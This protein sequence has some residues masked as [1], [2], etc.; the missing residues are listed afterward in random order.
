MQLSPPL[1]LL[2]LFLED[3]ERILPGYAGLIQGI[4]V[5]E[6][7]NLS[8]YNWPFT[9]GHGA[10]SNVLGWGPQSPSRS[11]QMSWLVSCWQSVPTRELTNAQDNKVYKARHFLNCR[12]ISIIVYAV[13]WKS[14]FMHIGKMGPQK[15][16]CK[17]KI[18]PGVC[19]LLNLVKLCLTTA[20]GD[21]RPIK[22]TLP[23]IPSVS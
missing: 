3:K 21:R 19:S 22:P 23:E 15:C 4:L 20:Q 2:L 16:E 17:S 14:H 6:V 13:I 5:L 11:F 8:V 7:E 10:L 18:Q 9:N 12:S 1:S